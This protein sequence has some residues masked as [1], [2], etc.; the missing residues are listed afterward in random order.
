VKAFAVAA[1][2]GAMLFSLGPLGA[3]GIAP[4]APA[5]SATQLTPGVRLERELSGAEFHTYRIAA[6]A[7]DF[8][9]LTIEQQGID[10]AVT[11]TRPDRRDLLA[12]DASGEDFGAETVAA[13]ADVSGVHVITVRRAPSAGAHGRYVIHLED[14]RAAT[15]E[16]A[17]R[18]D[19]ER[20][21]ERG[22]GLLLTN[23]PAAYGKALDEFHDAI[24]RYRGLGDRRGELK[25]AIEIA[26][27][28]ALLVQPGALRSAQLAAELAQKAGAP[29]DRARALRVLGRALERAGDRQAALKAYDE[30]SALFRDVH[31]LFGEALTVNDEGI[32][33]GQTGDAEQAVIKFEQALRLARTAHRALSPGVLNNLGIAYKDL[34]EYEKSLNA[35]ERAVARARTD[36]DRNLEA[37]ILNN[38][39]NV[40]RLQGRHDTALKLHT[41]A[42]TLARET[43]G[44]E[45]EARSLNTVG[46]TYYALGD[47]GKALDYHRQ[48]LAIRRELSD[49]A[50]QAASL[51][52][53]GRALHRLGESAQALDA[54]HEALSIRQAIREDYGTPATLRNLAVVERDR[55]DLQDALRDARAAVDLDE[56][57]RARITSPELRATYVAAE[58]DKYELL[59]DVL[60]ALHTADP[61]AGHAAAALTVSERARSRVLLESL[62][63][64]RV[65]LRQGIEPALLERERSLQKQLGAASAQLSRSLAGSGR[66]T[67]AASSAQQLERL[68]AEYQGLES[69]IRE[70]S[71]R[72]AAFTQ[73]RP[74]DAAAI[75]RSV[76]DEETVL[77]EYAL[78]EEKSWLWAVTT[79]AVTP[80]ELPPRRAI[81]AVARSLYA[82]FIARQPLDGEG[83]AAYTARI[84]AADRR[85]RGE[86]AAASRMLLGGI[87]VQLNGEWRNKR[88]AIVASGALQYLPFA[89]LPVPP[90]AA[91]AGSASL[92]ETVPLSATHEIV[93]I[94]SASVVAGLRQETAARSAAR[95]TVAIVAD[96]VFDGGDPRV[97]ARRSSGDG[98]GAHAAPALSRLPFSRDEAN[99][100]A[101]LVDQ[102]DTLK[103]T[104]FVASRT[105][106]LS[107]ALSRHRIVHLATH[108]IVDSQRPSL[109]ALVLSLVD[110]HGGRQNGY[111]RLP[112]IYNMRLD[113]DLVVLS[114]CQTALGKEIRGEGLV[115]L[116]RAFFYAGAPR[117]VASLWE[118]NDLATA[119][120]MKRF[121]RGMLQDHVRP[122][123]ALRAAQ[124]EMS[125]DPRWASPYFWA[126]FVLQGEWR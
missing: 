43:G 55:G 24:D 91:A 98:Q 9:H 25:T 94:P 118:V 121:Y 64:A 46:Q 8:I 73:P 88:L 107:G 23:R 122:A 35:Y 49:L 117:V 119:E 66:E 67:Q 69:E 123:A 108:G 18:V 100:I 80:V 21:F 29:P 47:Y 124:V 30:A 71:P 112:D 28:E 97:V 83:A 75:Q 60:Q 56:T 45:N 78:G 44:R 74:L 61:D 42:L 63:D 68:T 113:A 34:G 37:T 4:G 54:L 51:E 16:D 57:L 58:Q 90:A 125:H 126:G 105:T 84:A 114:A 101:A 1:A 2:C 40:A 3:A 5:R 93:A 79:N 85:L 38:M 96:P 27:T 92:T 62:L 104:D 14:V 95:P 6:T 103:A 10:V 22:R 53:V 19:A 41:T 102:R 32:I 82:R 26:G 120:L 87:A 76:L 81:D 111:L 106:V 39:G 15:A 89:A 86:A 7:G 12:V 77:L 65:D 31:D 99:A 20:A 36:H 17:T 72:Y 59:V 48:A 110:E 50:A 109:S 70:R 33:Y 116:T 52:G 115:G 13:V 11:L